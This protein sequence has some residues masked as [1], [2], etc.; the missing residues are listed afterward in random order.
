MEAYTH[1]KVPAET[2][3]DSI[4]HDHDRPVSP[5][6]EEGEITGPALTP[7]LSDGNAG[8]LSK[9]TTTLLDRKRSSSSKF[10]LIIFNIFY[11]NII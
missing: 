8:I 2:N 1:V 3:V 7:P 5:S 6:L 9:Q 10:K 11:I 4:N